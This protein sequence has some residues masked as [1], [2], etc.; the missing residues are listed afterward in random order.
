MNIVNTHQRRTIAE[1]F[2]QTCNIIHMSALA[3]SGSVAAQWVSYQWPGAPNKFVMVG[4]WYS[5]RIS[6]CSK[7]TSSQV[8]GGYISPGGVEVYVLFPLSNVLWI[9][10]NT[11]ATPL[12]SDAQT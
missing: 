6:S 4:V 12:G 10:H 5:K 7:R 11:W 8:I 9:I 3:S 2:H 1:P